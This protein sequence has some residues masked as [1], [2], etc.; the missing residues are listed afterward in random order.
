MQGGRKKERKKETYFLHHCEKL[1]N[2]SAI[3]DSIT[4][5]II[6]SSNVTQ[7]PHNLLLNS[8]VGGINETNQL[9]KS[10]R[11]DDSWCLKPLSNYHTSYLL[12]RSRSNIGQHPSSFILE[13]RN[14]IIGEEVCEARNKTSVND[15]FDWR[16]LVY[17]LQNHLCNIPFERILRKN[18]TLSITL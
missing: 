1:I 18:W 10:P 6:I 9:R 13:L 7:S 17:W 12:F 4:I 16:N 8:H 15:Q 3:S 11:I 5:G 2:H 14:V